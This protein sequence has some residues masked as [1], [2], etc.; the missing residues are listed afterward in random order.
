[1]S[2]EQDQ[3]SECLDGVCDLS[4]ALQRMDGDQGLL[5]EV[6]EI[7]LEDNGNTL[8]ELRAAIEKREPV[9]L[10]RAAH[11]IKGAVGNF[12]AK[13]SGDIALQIE[14]LS[15]GGQIDAAIALAAPLE[16]EVETLANALVAYRRRV[17]A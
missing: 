9:V 11:T 2:A 13:R 15:K 7:F 12:A 14:S 17:A 8:L 10:Q 4:V 5:L 1:M 6:I 3:P 16:R